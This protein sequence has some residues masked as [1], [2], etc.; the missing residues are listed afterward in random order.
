MEKTLMDAIRESAK[1]YGITTDA[2]ARLYDNKPEIRDMSGNPIYE[3]DA[4]DVSNLMYKAGTPDKPNYT[5]LN[6]TEY[7][8][9]TYADDGGFKSV[10]DLKRTSPNFNMYDELSKKTYDNSEKFTKQNFDYSDVQDYNNRMS[11]RI[12]TDNILL[13]TKSGN[14]FAGGYYPESKFIQ[15][16]P[17]SSSHTVQHEI[18]HSA[19]NIPDYSGIFGGIKKAY[20]NW[21]GDN[22]YIKEFNAGKPQK[23]RTSPMELHANVT[24]TLRTLRENGIKLDTEEAVDKYVKD[25][26]KRS[27]NHELSSDEEL[28]LKFSIGHNEAIQK[29]IKEDKVPVADIIKALLMT[30]AKNEQAP[31]QQPNSIIDNGMDIS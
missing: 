20:D 4:V 12:P 1:E 24:G 16:S 14:S 9:N 23:Y 8:N 5:V 17:D 19:Q 3:H 30:T 6:P 10:M 2:A 29:M 25:F 11:N 7:I 13:Y 28:S 22:D 21:R 18:T 27:D 26:I 15:V 31:T